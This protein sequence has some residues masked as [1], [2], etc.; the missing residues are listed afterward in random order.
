M[1]KRDC[2]FVYASILLL[3]ILFASCRSTRLLEEGQALVTKTE[4]E[5]IEPRLTEQAKAYIPPDLRPNSR[6]NLFIYNL[7]NARKGRY[8]TKNIRN[9]GEPPHVLDSA[10]V[11]FSTQQINRYLA[12]KGYFNAEVSNNIVLKGKRAHI[13]FH[14][15]LGVPYTVRN[16]HVNI[17]DPQL[18]QVYAEHGVI[19]RKV[20]PAM[21]YDADSLVAERERIY[22]L[23]RQQGYYEYLRQYMRV[24]V[25]TSLRRNQADLKL[26]VDNP[27]GQAAHT[28]FTID[29]SFVIIQHSR[30]DLN[31]VMPKKMVLDNQVYVED[32]TGRFHPAPIARYL[33]HHHGDAYNV[34]LENLTYDRLYELNGFRSVKIAYSKPDSN[35]LN[36]YYELTPRPYMA[37]QIEGEYTFNS[38]MSGFN[39]GNTFTHRNLFGGLEQLEVK[40]RYG[41]LFDSRLPGNLLDRV[42]NNDFQVGVNITVPR[43]LTPFS[44]P[45][46]GRNGLPRT[47]FSANIQA[48]DQFQTYSNRY[49]SGTLSYNW[50]DTRY[51]HHTLTPL[52]LEYRYGQLNEEF[53]QRLIDQGF[54]LYVRSN[55]R[56]Y[57]GLGSQYVY[58]LNAVRLSRLEDFI[59][60][61]GALD[62]SGNLLGVASQVIDFQRNVDGE[63]EVF[64]VPYLQYAKAETDLRYY[65]YFGGDR[66]LIVR[67]N[68]GIAVPYGNNSS[69][70]IFEKSFFGGG[71]N[72]IRAWQART[73]GPGNYNRQ[74]LDPGLRLNLRNLD[75]LGEVKLEGNVEYRFKVLN[76]LFGAKLKAATFAD[77]GN[78]WRI[79]EN[80]LNPGGEFRFDKFLGQMAI[81]TGVGLRFDRG[82]F[83]IRLDAGLKVRDPQFDGAN[84]WVITELF[85]SREFKE[86]YRIT[87]A[88]DRYNFVQYN[89]GI[90]MPF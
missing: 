21:R 31:H 64:G 8:R 80:E 11:D 76:D 26:I 18:A 86:Q 85:N 66:Q 14:A 44:V 73:L 27:E 46:G 78:V 37:N 17:A 5:G 15:N 65:R 4:I 1:D 39:V 58:T 23:M 41:V 67:L 43:L 52:V 75:Q 10:L 16:V 22:H 53:A 35:R 89:F 36:V 30:D 59:Y 6:I 25:D 82:Y 57:F 84:Q 12:S 69:L 3:L 70:L 63:K 62:L 48:F 83:V 42:F 20:R 55:N 56:A 90:G 49:F 88:P 68:P 24:D 29:S 33:F 50:S 47:I 54:L 81:G 9:V 7:A 32:Y 45:L 87:N 74:V 19:G 34:D 40:L 61:R 77:F 79:K 13:Y 2:L 38:G 60:F 72:G 71:M 51:K 28:K